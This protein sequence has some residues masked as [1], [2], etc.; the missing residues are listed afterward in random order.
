ME[1]LDRQPHSETAHCGV[2]QR[3]G[4][5]NWWTGRDGE[6]REHALG[7]TALAMRLVLV[8]LE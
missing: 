2:R 1:A 6:G 4:G 7:T 3:T 5:V 8:Q